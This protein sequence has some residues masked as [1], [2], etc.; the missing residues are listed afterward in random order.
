MIFTN[1]PGGF[2][3]G[4]FIFLFFPG[5]HVMRSCFCSFCSI[6]YGLFLF[7]TRPRLRARICDIS[8]C[9]WGA[10]ARCFFAGEQRPE[11]DG[12]PEVVVD[13]LCRVVLA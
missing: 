1:Q 3:F 12:G 13:A 8:V 5:G 11:V 4:S 6:A 9:S 10:I 7:S 2:F